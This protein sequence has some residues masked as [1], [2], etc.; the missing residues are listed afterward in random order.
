[1][2]KRNRVGR[3]LLISFLVLLALAGF[4]AAAPLIFKGP[5][6]RAAKDA[7]NKNVN[8][9]VNW[10]DINVSIFKHFPNITVSVDDLS[11]INKAPFKGDTLAYI[12]NTSVTLNFWTVVKG[13][14]YSIESFTLTR[15][16]IN[17]LSDSLGRT[18][19]DVALK[20]STEKAKEN[21]PPTKFKVA[22]KDYAI[23]NANIRYRDQKS[24]TIADLLNFSHTGSGNFT[25]EV[26]TLKTKTDVGTINAKFGG[27]KY[28]D[29]VT[30]SLTVPVEVD[31]VHSKYTFRDNVFKLNDLVAKLS[32]YVALPDSNTIAMDLHFNTTETDFKSLL[33]L[34]PGVLGKEAKDVKATGK[35]TLAA[36]AKGNYTATS[37][38]AFTTQLNVN[39]ATVQYA[40]APAPVSD[41]N[42]DLDVQNPGGSL[43]ATRIALN[44]AHLRFDKQIVDMSATVAT[45]LSDPAIAGKL[46][47]AIDLG[48]VSRMVPLPGVASLSGT[49]DANIAAAGRMSALDKKQY[50]K[51]EMSG[52]ATFANINYKATDATLPAVAVSAAAMSFNPKDVVLKTFEGKVGETQLSASGAFHNLLSYMLKGEMLR[53]DFFVKSPFINVNEWLAKESPA[54]STDKKPATDQAALSVVHLPTNIDFTLQT[55]AGKILYDNFELNNFAGEL[56]LRA[57]I[58]SLSGLNFNMLGGA[59]N[60][61]GTYDPTKGEEPAINFQL[62]LK[63]LDIAE[64]FRTF[65]TVQK[66]APVAEYTEGRFS[67]TLNF[68]GRLKTDMTPNLQSLTGGGTLGLMNAVVKNFL[69]LEK[70]AS[71]V[72][73]DELKQLN[74]KD[75]KFGIEFENGRV[76]I[77]RFPVKVAGIDGAIQGSNGFDQTIDYTVDIA[78]PRARLGA[79]ANTLVDGLRAQLKTSTGVDVPLSDVVNLQAKIGGTATNPKVTV[80]MRQVAS[81]AVNSLKDAC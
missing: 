26:F 22:L 16:N 73:V 30:A 21:T 80:N 20:D 71:V 42:F 54:T 23:R 51:F 4:L 29:G 57:G 72:K 66:F 56:V 49:V 61:A 41:I 76:F 15:P 47:G 1:M 11:L 69:P 5:I 7:A 12:A 8:G 79:Q 25:E 77:T 37:Y 27:V 65:V 38:P 68:I 63:N 43:D 10:S 35:F 52:T 39:N 32:G 70:L 45:P 58:L 2:A 40:G 9:I 33:S 46:V 44:K 19:W 28:L 53:A 24:G 60:M 81:S 48:A 13:D 36:T 64:S 6:M 67:S 75:T 14:Q 55:K 62:G 50:D 34:L 3:I 17:L 59:V 18:N 31:L 74:L 78:V